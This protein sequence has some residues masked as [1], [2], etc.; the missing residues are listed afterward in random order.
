[1][2]TQDELTLTWENGNY[3]G[4]DT[5]IPA[6][7][8]LKTINAILHPDDYERP[9]KIPGRTTAAAFP[10][11]VT[12]ANAKGLA[13]CRFPNND[14]DKVLLLGANA[15][16]AALADTVTLG[17]WTSLKDQ[18]AT[19]AVFTRTGSFLK[20]LP[21]GDQRYILFTGAASERPLILDEDGNIRYLSLNPPAAPTLTPITGTFGTVLHPIGSAICVPTPTSLITT[22]TFLQPQWAYDTVADTVDY[23][24]TSAYAYCAYQAPIP[25]QVMTRAWN[26]AASGTPGVACKL[27]ITVSL[28]AKAAGPW[29]NTYLEI[30]VS[31]N[32]L[33]GTYFLMGQTSPS[34]TNYTRTYQVDIAAAQQLNALY[35]K[36]VFSY[37]ATC[38]VVAQ[39]FDIELRPLTTT[40]A[41]AIGVGTFSYV[42]TERYLQ[43]LADGSKVRVESPPSD[44]VS[45]TTTSLTT[46]VLL[47]FPTNPALANGTTDGVQTTALER[48]IYR[49]T[50]TGTYPDLG[51]CGIALSSAL[52]WI[53]LFQD[54]TTITLGSPGLNIGY[55]GD[56]PFPVAGQPSS[57]IDATLHKGCIVYIPATDPTQVA[58]SAPGW[59]EYYPA[60]QSFGM[61]PVGRGEG[62][63]GIV[64]LGDNLIFFSRTRI[65]RIR[66]L[67]MA[68]SNNFDLTRLQTD[69]LSHNEGL[70]G[71]PLSY[72]LFQGTEGQAACAWV[73]YS[74]IWLT[75]GYPVAEKGI[76]CRRLT[77]NKSW[78][79]DV[80]LS[81]LQ[82]SR[83]TFDPDLQVI[84]FDYYNREGELTCD[85]LHVSSVHWTKVGGDAAL[86]KWSGPHTLTALARAIGEH[87]NN[88]LCWDLTTTDVRNARQGVQDG[89]ADILT[90]IETGWIYPFGPRSLMHL[91]LAA[92]GHSDWGA[93][94][95]CDI[96]IQL[97]NERT[98]IIQSIMCPGVSLRG[99]R[100]TDLGFLNVS[101]RALKVILRHLGKTTSV[102]TPIRAFG[103][104]TLQVEAVDDGRLE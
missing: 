74:G 81:R 71:S 25:H 39:V 38:G 53:D 26:F 43:T 56:G 79:S 98:G 5:R 4:D 94:E 47:T 33:N 31:L 7:F 102:G 2:A 50:S 58:W 90:H 97:R 89:T 41:G 8:V 13:Y 48:I 23:L 15:I 76:G 82:E 46:G 9:W 101:G 77:M 42:T 20:T 1:M 27:N 32:G 45:I 54:P 10:S 40:L 61:L 75:D 69:V 91:Y 55:I 99:S 14:L 52:T 88:L 22:G 3:G 51:K 93:S 59:P 49:S 86:P 72:V 103:P 16:Y 34:T 87:D 95:A 24:K 29:G 67:P 62:G 83:L 21:T 63:V 12:S 100:N 104:M 6:G 84:I 11:G 60:P 44:F 80:D 37:A 57:F 92:L 28:S 36:A 70:A 64:S 30:Y 65:H 17:P 68:N 96:E 18:Q 73:S 78:R 66:E 85:Y 19:P 35:V